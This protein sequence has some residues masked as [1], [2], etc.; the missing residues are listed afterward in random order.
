LVEVK[1]FFAHSGSAQG[2]MRFFD[3]VSGGN[4]AGQPL[5]TNGNCGSVMP[6]IQTR[7]FST[8][9]HRIEVAATG[10]GDVWLDSLTLT[11]ATVPVRPTAWALVKE[12]YRE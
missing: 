1:A 6:P 7:V 10:N 3:A 2:A 5:M 11:D 8:T 9:V 12:L 4:E